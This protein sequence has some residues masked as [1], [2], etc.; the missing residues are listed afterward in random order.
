MTTSTPVALSGDPSLLR[1]LNLQAVL[2]VLHRGGLHTITELALAAG[3]SRPTTKQAVT[4]LIKAGWIGVSDSSQRPANMI[5]RP[6]Q[7]FEF[8][9]DAGHVLGV[10]IGAHKAVALIADLNG[11]LLARA[12]LT[13][14]PTWPAERRLEALDE[15]IENVVNKFGPGLDRI[16]HA[17]VATPG[18][19]G[20][21]GTI[22]HCTVIPQWEG[23]RLGDQVTERFGLPTEAVDDMAMAALA[24]HWRGAAAGV[25]DVVYLHTGRRIGTGILIGGRPHRGRNGAAAEIGLWRGLQ[26][27]AAYDRFLQLPHD[28]RLT[29]GE[30]V[31]KVF[32]DAAAGD[33]VAQARI[34]EFATDLAVGLAPTIVAVDPELVVIG[35]GI[36]AAGEAIRDPLRKRIQEETRFPPRVVCSILG[37]ESVALGSVR[38]A[39][40]K[41][42]EELFAKLA[43]P[44]D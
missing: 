42:E 23:Q 5:G 10:D 40:D 6:A 34:D 16:G 9:P 1:R 20:P 43:P 30:A 4:D 44:V 21:D 22:T 15:V 2:H 11:T 32:E 37:D 29:A 27:E 25:N 38:L 36:S 18:V 28:A 3:I 12:R 41:A 33:E 26:W 13:L 39:L 31:K 24:E 14:D 17:A 8:R 19:V 7:A 35:G